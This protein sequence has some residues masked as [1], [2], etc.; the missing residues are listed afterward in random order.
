MHR[1]FNKYSIQKPMLLHKSELLKLLK[2]NLTPIKTV[3]S[4]DSSFTNFGEPQYQ[5]ASLILQK[6]R[7]NENN[8]FYSFRQDASET[9]R[10]MTLNSTVNSSY[11]HESSDN[12]TNREIFFSIFADR[13]RN[14]WTKKNYYR[15]FQLANLYVGLEELVNAEFDKRPFISQIPSRIITEKIQHVYETVNPPI[16]QIQRR[17]FAFYKVFPR[18]V[19]I[20]LLVFLSVEN[21]PF[22]IATGLKFPTTIIETNLK[23]I[24]QDMGMKNMP[25]TVL[26]VARKGSDHLRRRVFNTHKSAQNVLLVQ[27][28]ASELMRN[29]NNYEKHKLRNNSDLSRLYPRSD[30]RFISSPLV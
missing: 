26:D 16:S 18:E 12:N 30:R 6:K 7:V 20:D 1:L 21:F 28:V 3:L 24:L 2:D 15:A 29:K 11:Y 14:Y 17:N 25:D 27:A 5:E 10:S 22:R 9:I 23:M 19:N 8:F 13:D 4:I